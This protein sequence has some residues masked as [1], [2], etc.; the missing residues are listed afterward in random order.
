MAPKK[1]GNSESGTRGKVVVSGTVIEEVSDDAAKQQSV[2]LTYSDALPQGHIAGE[3]LQRTLLF[4]CL[5]VLIVCVAFYTPSFLSFLYEIFANAP[6]PR[7]IATVS[8]IIVS[9]DANASP[10]LFAYLNRDYRDAVKRH[11]LF[12]CK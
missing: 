1:A 9:L 3:S 7:S 12:C 10:L 5:A 8:T 11:V 4:R 6:A 2:V